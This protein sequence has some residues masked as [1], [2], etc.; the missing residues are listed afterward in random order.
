MQVRR[1]V[2]IRIFLALRKLYDGCLLIHADWAVFSAVRWAENVQVFTKSRI[3]VLD[4]WCARKVHSV[5]TRGEKLDGCGTSVGIQ[6][7]V[8]DTLNM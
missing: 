3:T 5:F 2:A 6:C 7:H 1:S 8:I 4:E